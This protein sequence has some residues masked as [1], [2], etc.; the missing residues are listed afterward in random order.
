MEKLVFKQINF[1]ESLNSK[2]KQNQKI[3]D[4]ENKDFDVYNLEALKEI[5]N[6]KINYQDALKKIINNLGQEKI[7]E[8]I[9][10]AYNQDSANVAKLE[11]ERTWKNSSI[12]FLDKIC[13]LKY[14]SYLVKGLEA[15]LAEIDNQDQ[16]SESQNQLIQKFLDNE[17]KYSALVNSLAIYNKGLVRKVIKRCFSNLSSSTY[18]QEDLFQEGYLALVQAIESFDLKKGKVLSTYAFTVIFNEIKRFTGFFTNSDI[19]L[20]E[21]WYADI[22]KVQELIEQNQG[23]INLH[24]LASKCNFSLERATELFFWTKAI[25]FQ[26]LD[27]ELGD[28]NEN[29]GFNLYNLLPDAGSGVQK[30]EDNTIKR[31]SSERFIKLLAEHLNQQEQQIFCLLNGFEI[32]FKNYELISCTEE[33]L[34]L[35][36]VGEKLNL[37]Y[38]TVRQKQKRI[39][40]RI[41]KIKPRLL[42]IF[43]G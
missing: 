28:S 21:A 34:S 13:F 22:I 18:S 35:R 42:A 1:V 37:S 6:Q 39:L 41:R 16:K 7:S 36:V 3:D 2:S 29:N 19:R 17:R 12:D 32:D 11:E 27:E 4:Q 24:E 43:Y 15:R 14:R 23:R 31:L 25:N 5:I 33:P 8:L 40:A 26:S 9:I 30:L 20:P 38:E 10:K